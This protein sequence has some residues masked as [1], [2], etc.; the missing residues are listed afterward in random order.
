MNSSKTIFA[1]LM[2]F[3]PSVTIRCCMER[4]HGNYKV[5]SFSCWDQFLTL[6]FANSRIERVT[7]ISKRV[8]EQR[9][10]FTPFT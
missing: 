5:K 3:V 1:Q 10:S 8:C 4:D 2:D 7:E 9:S 6:A